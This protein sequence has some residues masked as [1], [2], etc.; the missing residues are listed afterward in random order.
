MQSRGNGD[1]FVLST[2][3]VVSRGIY[4]LV[5]LAED[6][7][8]AIT[9]PAISALHHLTTTSRRF[10][11]NLMRATDNA[12]L[13]AAIAAGVTGRSPLECVQKMHQQTWTNCR[14]AFPAQQVPPLARDSPWS[15]LGS[16][17]TSF[18][19]VWWTAPLHCICCRDCVVNLMKTNDIQPSACHPSTKERRVQ[20]WQA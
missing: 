9:H 4:K 14:L 10:M 7:D 1:I 13:L 8:P 20:G 15:T 17:A 3:L 19:G 11:A 2:Q 6:A 18:F 16:C 12:S 5:E